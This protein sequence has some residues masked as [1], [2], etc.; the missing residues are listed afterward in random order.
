MQGT[1]RSEGASLELNIVKMRDRHEEVESQEGRGEVAEVVSFYMPFQDQG[2]SASASREYSRRARNA[3]SKIVHSLLKSVSVIRYLVPVA[4]SQWSH[5]GDLI[6]KD[7]FHRP[8]RASCFVLEKHGIVARHPT[9]E[10]HF[11]V[12][13]TIPQPRSKSSQS[14]KNSPVSTRFIIAHNEL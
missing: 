1:A 7:D 2:T 9:R 8:N 6:D 11:P 12:L 4:T 5:L 10:I 3:S 14:C 13:F